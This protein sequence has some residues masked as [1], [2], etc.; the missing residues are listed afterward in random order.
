MAG[1]ARYDLPVTVLGADQSEW[2][3]VVGFEDYYAVSDSGLVRRTKAMK[4]TQAG[5][6]LEPALSTRRQYLT[7]ILCRNQQKTMAMVHTLVAAAFIGPRPDGYE[8]NH[9]D[10]HKL[11]NRA[12]NLEYVTKSGN[13]KHAVDL[14]FHRW[15]EDR[16]IAKAVRGC[17][18]EHC[19][20]ILGR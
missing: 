7:V 5:R 10:G 13:A 4:G 6:I 19:H 16:R 2:R 15:S 11:N 20:R 17:G 18:C 9:K 3:P 12:D 14:G 8:I 1:F